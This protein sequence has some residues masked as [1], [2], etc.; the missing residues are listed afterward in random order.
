[1]PAEDVKLLA[2]GRIY[3]GRQAQEV[4]LVDKLGDL[5]DALNLA[6][7]IA[8]L[9]KPARIIRDVDPIEQFMSF[10]DAKA[11]NFGGAAVEKALNASPRLEYRWYGN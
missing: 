8:K 3:S 7:D 9:E 5:E 6:A 10:I 4:K 2:D 1:M 11:G